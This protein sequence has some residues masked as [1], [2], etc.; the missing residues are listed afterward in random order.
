MLGAKETD[1]ATAVIFAEMGLEI[2]GGFVVRLRELGTP[3]HEQAV[4]EAAHDGEDH[5]DVGLSDATAIVVVRHIQPLVKS[6]LDPPGLSVELDPAGRIEFAVLEIGDQ[7]DLFGLVALEVAAQAGDLSRKRE[8]HLLGV[9]RGRA[10]GTFFPTA[11]V[12]FERSRL[13]GRG[14][15]R[16]ENPPRGRRSASR[17]AGAIRV[18]CPSP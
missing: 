4:G 11:F 15:F 16:G 18:D 1:A 7:T 3:F 12:G 17:W 2:G 13:S 9:D 5:H 8:S 6:A 14:V 10:D